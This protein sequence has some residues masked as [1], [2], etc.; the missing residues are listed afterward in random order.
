MYSI[1]SPAV[2]ITERVRRDPRCVARLERMMKHVVTDQV[3]HVSDEELDD[4]VA[5]G[6]LQPQGRTGMMGGGSDTPERV[7]LFD[8]FSWRTMDEE[9]AYAAQYRGV[10]SVSV[11]GPWTFRDKGHLRRDLDG[12]CQT[13][14]ELHSAE[15]CLHGCQYCFIGRVL[16]LM[17]NLEEYVEHL[18]DLMKTNPWLQ[19]FKYDNR[20]DQ[21][22]LEPEYG[23]SDIM[24]RFFADQP[25][26]YLLLY[27]KSDNVDHLLDLPHNGHTIVNWSMSCDWVSREIERFTPTV[28]QRIE[29]SRKCQETGYPVRARFSP[30]MPIASWREEYGATVR[31]YLRKV[32][33]DVITLDVVGWMTAG[34]LKKCV[35]VDLFAPEYREFIEEIDQQGDPRRGKPYNPDGKHIFPPELRAPIYRFMI[36]EIRRCDPN[37]RITICM[38]TPEMWEQFGDELGMSPDEYVCCCGPTSVPGNPLLSV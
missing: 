24:V 19:L 12:I 22:C 13:A 30:I 8:A 7:L 9:K 5:K 16:A 21:I 32:K 34:T 29:A 33:P 27:T 36:D 1:K 20:T 17:L 11:L 26:R 38:E 23:A 4:I 3:V 37:Q 15:G 31:E 10:R 35:N 28:W 2:Y 18:Q 25:E 14:Y 6:S